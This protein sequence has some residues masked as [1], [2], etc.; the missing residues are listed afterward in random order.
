M[1]RTRAIGVVGTLAYAAMWTPLVAVDVA[2]YVAQGATPIQ[3]LRGAAWAVLPVAAL[4]ISAIRI[5]E[6]V[7]EGPGTPLGSA[8]RY[9]ALIA[10][11]AVV[12]ALATVGFWHLE[13]RLFTPTKPQT[14]NYLYA[15]Y[16]A[17]MNS[18]VCVALAGVAVAKTQ[19]RRAEA[20]AARASRAESLRAQAHLALL[21][22]QLNPHFVL[23]VLHSLVGLVRRDPALAERALE[24]LGGLLGHGLR[25]SREDGDRVP[26]REEWA[27]V[28]TY[29]EL[30]KL[31]LGERLHL[32]LD[33]EAAALE[34]L[35]PAFTLQPL[36][37]NAIVHAIAPRARGGR[38][39]VSARVGNGC[40]RLEVRDDGPGLGAAAED[41]VHGAPAAGNGGLGLRLLRERLAALYPGQ[42]TL[43]LDPSPGGGL[44]A[45]LD[46]PR[47]EEP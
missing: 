28:R 37:E 17:L 46:L 10:G 39:E 43:R 5:A 2:L 23:N 34:C 27:F 44:C 19:A 16:Q 15:G 32:A 47:A 26:L 29:L 1:G 9:G 13:L 24:S 25:L 6:R 30:E 20:E 8:L 12:T 35:V 4:G 14:V 31:R 22:T 11:F 40:V 38:L 41:A 45:R 42:E 3:A 36:V 7:A 18:M 33:A 21:R